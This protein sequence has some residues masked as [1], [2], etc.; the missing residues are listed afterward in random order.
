[1]DCSMPGFPVLCCLLEFVQAHVH[2]VGDAIQPSHPLSPP[3][4]PDLSI[5][6]LQD[7]FQW[8]GIG[9]SSQQVGRVLELQLQHQSLQWILRDDFLSDWPVYHFLNFF[10]LFSL[11][12]SDVPA[13]LQVLKGPLQ[14]PTFPFAVANQLLLVSLLEHLSHV[15][16]P[17]PL[18]SRQVF[19][20]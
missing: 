12:E 4:P 14:Q 15:H 9:W 16:E 11:A 5:S 3:F 6:Q 20:C 1:M 7:C 19:K 18:R 13:E 10:F 17:N 2:W 8:V